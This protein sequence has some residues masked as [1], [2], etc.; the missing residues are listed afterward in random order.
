MFNMGIEVIQSVKFKYE[1]NEEVLRL[2]KDFRDIVNYC[3]TKLL[4]L[5]TTSASKLH[6]VTYHELKRKYDYNTQ[7]FISAY[8]VA[9][10]IVKSSKRKRRRKPVVK[11][12]FMK[13][14]PLLTKFDGETL[15]LSIRPREFVYLP[16]VVGEY[17]QKF[18]DEWKKGKLRIGMMTLN[19]KYVIIP[20][21]REI[22]WEKTDG[23]IAFDI[24]E[25]SLVGVSTKGQQ[26]NIDLSE[27]K[28]IHDCYFEK[29]RNI[30]RK[31]AKKPRVKK[32]ILLKYRERERRR[33]NDYLHKV[34]KKVAEYITQ[35]RLET[36]FENLKNIRKSVNRKIKRY[37]KHS[38]KVQKISIH[39]KSLKRRLN[40]WGFRKL[41]ILIEYKANLNGFKV[42]YLSPFGTSKFCSICGGIIAPNEQNCPQCGMDRH[43]NACI[44]LLKKSQDERSSGSLDGSLM[45]L[46]KLGCRASSNEVNQAETNGR[47]WKTR[48][49]AKEPYIKVT[50]LSTACRKRIKLEKIDK[51]DGYI[52]KRP[53][54][55]EKIEIFC[56]LVKNAVK[57]GVIFDEENNIKEVLPWE[58]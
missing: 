36:I 22:E 13:L 51:T 18:I 30:Q 20:F 57:E 9:Q 11:K 16:L 6:K 7:Y 46:M 12:L 3:I 43:V 27:V 45:R 1:P 50:N 5:K 2:L 23:T 54:S 10:S 40:S 4:E 14:S 28:R 29:R 41:Q 53:R 56:E 52:R 44:N 17:Q 32:R 15:R 58:D 48:Q 39:S 37:N 8:R 42:R 26:V 35:N 55:N 19:E 38:G 31:L 47:S 34:S 24:N 25:R 21:K 49:Q 33:I